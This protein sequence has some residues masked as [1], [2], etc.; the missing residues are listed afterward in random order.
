[1]SQIAPILNYHHIS[2]KVDYYTAVTMH[3]FVEQMNQIL[4]KF[5][6]VTMDELLKDSAPGHN[7][8]T[9]TFDDGYE[10]IQEALS[11]LASK[12][13]S[14][15]IFIPTQYIG[16]NNIW[17]HKATY[18][19]NALTEDQIRDCLAM[20]HIIGS[21]G[22]LHQCLT[23]LNAQE[24]Q[25]ELR[26]SKKYLNERFNETIRYFAYPY[27]FHNTQVRQQVSHFYDAAFATSKTCVDATDKYQMNRFS[28]NSTS[29]HREI[30][31]FLQNANER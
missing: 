13:M 16:K 23:K 30:F 28:V 24:L 7:V 5:K 27:G 25:Q 6:Y 3:S 22:V 11:F 29:T 18:I 8:F 12:K 21:H 20:G 15:L 14:A 17:N 9:L 10:D 26:E 2:E 31:T 1:M 4:K 19:A